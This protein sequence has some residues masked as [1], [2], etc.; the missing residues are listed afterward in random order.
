[1]VFHYELK[2]A[3][4][5]CELKNHRQSSLTI[6]EKSHY[7]KQN[8][9]IFKVIVFL[10]HIRNNFSTIAILLYFAKINICCSAKNN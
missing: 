3:C 9:I 5:Q 2:F 6:Y 7:K 10:F 8:K 4:N 1:M